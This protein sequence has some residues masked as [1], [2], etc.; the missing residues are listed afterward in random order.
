MK[1]SSDSTNSQEEDIFAKFV[2]STPRENANENTQKKSILL[3][4]NIDPSIDLTSA[5][6]I[7]G[8]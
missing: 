6:G 2:D 5:D 1:N 3:R 8:V 4:S 7:P